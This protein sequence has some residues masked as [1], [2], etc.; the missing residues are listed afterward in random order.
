[1]TTTTAINGLPYPQLSDV[2]DEVAQFSA[3]SAV[4]DSRYVPR[5]TNAA[6]RD[7]ANPSPVQGQL[8]YL[9]QEKLLTGRHSASWDVELLPTVVRKSTPQSV[10]NSTSLV[11]DA[12]L[13][14]SLLANSTY[15]IEVVLFVTGDV[16]PNG[17]IMIAWTDLSTLVGTQV[18][19]PIGVRNLAGNTNIEAASMLMNNPLYGANQYGTVSTSLVQTHHE[20]LFVTTESSPISC[21]MRWAQSVASTTPTT[22]NQDSHLKYW[23]IA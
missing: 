19:L 1:M 2:K 18:R 14:M 11:P 9:T 8:A 7:V 15:A 16:V 10:T 21:T 20:F 12:Q 22:I 17:G 5:Y 3:F 23:K 13:K 4:A 6:T